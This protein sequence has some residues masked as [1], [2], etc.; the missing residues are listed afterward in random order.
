MQEWLY[1][2]SGWYLT[3]RKGVLFREVSSIQGSRI[4]GF[5]SSLLLTNLMTLH[6][7]NQSYIAKSG[8][9]YVE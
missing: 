7:E 4:E 1:S 5:H 6:A 9:V 2:K 8:S 3:V